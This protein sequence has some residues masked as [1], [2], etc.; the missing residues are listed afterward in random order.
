M[1]KAKHLKKISNSAN[2]K[3]KMAIIQNVLIN[4][5]MEGKTE[6]E[7]NNRDIDYDIINNLVEKGYTYYQ[8]DLSTNIKW[9]DA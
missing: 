8:D 4:A 5:A 6:V 7:I 2:S 1:L 9:E 3:S